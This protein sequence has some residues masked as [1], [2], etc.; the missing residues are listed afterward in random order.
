MESVV[1]NVKPLQAFGEYDVFTQRGIH[2]CFAET[3]HPTRLIGFSAPLYLQLARK[4]NNIAM[5]LIEYLAEKR[6]SHYSEIETI[7]ICNARQ[8]VISYL[9]KC[10]QDTDNCQLSKIGY[11]K[12]LLPAPK[13]QIAAYLGMKPETFS[14]VLTALQKNGLIKINRREIFIISPDI[15][16]M[17]Q[18]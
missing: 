18:D 13:Y 15:F 5:A 7:T 3:T 6:S 17:V 2:D 14:R 11:Q 10:W 12:A 1:G 4:N 8:R 16:D 9:K